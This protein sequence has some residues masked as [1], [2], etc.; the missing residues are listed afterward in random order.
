MEII[1]NQLQV[2]KI[3]LAYIIS[4]LVG[5]SLLVFVYSSYIF[6][7]EAYVMLFLS[8]A[9]FLFFIY[10]IIIKPEYIYFAQIKNKII[11]KNYPA[12]PIFRNYKAFEI[13][14]KSLYS[15]KIQKSFL[16]KK[17]ELVLTIK[18][19]KGTG[20]YPPMSLSALSTNELKKLLT[21]LDK[22]SKE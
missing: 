6:T 17:I 12:R 22:Y 9:L 5:L 7:V 19:K 3:K 13:D 4:L 11:I 15:Y 21:F 2:A 8:I 20:N 16:N 10:L 18:T 14:L 1:N